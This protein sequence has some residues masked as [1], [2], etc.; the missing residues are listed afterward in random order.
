MIKLKDLIFEGP[1]DK[2]QDMERY[3]ERSLPSTLERNGSVDSDSSSMIVSYKGRI[4]PNVTSGREYEELKS[5][6]KKHINKLKRNIEKYGG[7]SIEFSYFDEWVGFDI[8]MA[9]MDYKS[10]EMIRELF[11]KPPNDKIAWVGHNYYSAILYYDSDD[12]S[13]TRYAKNVERI[14]RK[15]NLDDEYMVDDEWKEFKTSRET[16]RDKSKKK[17]TLINV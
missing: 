17:G 16:V 15:E 1:F 2:I 3:V 7:K 11:G 6:V 13:A 9:E 14:I 5:E 12:S 4:A 10:P 8:R